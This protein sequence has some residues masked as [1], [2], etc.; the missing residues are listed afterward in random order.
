MLLKK[1]WK[2]HEHIRKKMSPVILPAFSD[3]VL[4]FKISSLG[5]NN[6]NFR[7]HGPTRNLY[8]SSIDGIF[9]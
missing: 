1:F 9:C 7:T 4:G 3:N 8:Q 2:I 5:L 6:L